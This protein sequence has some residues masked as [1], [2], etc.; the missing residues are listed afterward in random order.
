MSKMEERAELLGLPEDFSS[1]SRV[2]MHRFQLQNDLE[3]KKEQAV[4]K[5]RD[6]A[7]HMLETADRV[8]KHPMGENTTYVGL[9]SLGEVQGRGQDLDRLIVEFC[10]DLK[11]RHE[12]VQALDLLPKEGK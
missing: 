7:R 5:M 9:N 4:E 3:H 10:S 8:E 6:L 11:H 12:L 2:D 1:W